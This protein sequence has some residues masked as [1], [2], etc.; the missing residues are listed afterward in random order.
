MMGKS[1]SSRWIDGLKAEIL[2]LRALCIAS[3]I[4]PNRPLPRCVVCGEKVKV[5]KG[6]GKVYPN[7]LFCSGKCKQQDWR[8]RMK[9]ARQEFG[10]RQ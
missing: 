5:M 2:R 3:N 10:G 9:K 7:R 6:R 4:D 1:T 8:N